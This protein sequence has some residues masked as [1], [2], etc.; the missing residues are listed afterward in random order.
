VIHQTLS[1]KMLCLYAECNY[2]ECDYAECHYAKCCLPESHIARVKT[3]EH[4]ATDL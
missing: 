1:I 3:V 2:V 4:Y